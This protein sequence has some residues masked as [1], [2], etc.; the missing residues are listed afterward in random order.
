MD[1]ADT[2]RTTS[3]RYNFTRQYKSSRKLLFVLYYLHLFKWYIFNDDIRRVAPARMHIHY[4]H[5]LK[6][7]ESCFSR[8]PRASRPFIYSAM[9]QQQQE[10]QEQQQPPP[11]PG[12]RPHSNAATCV[13][14][15]TS[16]AASQ[17]HSRGV[18]RAAIAL[19]YVRQSFKPGAGAATQVRVHHGLLS[20]RSRPM[21]VRVDVLLVIRGARRPPFDAVGHEIIIRIFI[22]LFINN[23]KASLDCER[24]VE[25]VRSS[26]S[27][28]DLTIFRR[29]PRGCRGSCHLC[30]NIICSHYGQYERVYRQYVIQ[31]DAVHL[32]VDYHVRRVLDLQAAAAARVHDLEKF[33]VFSVLAACGKI[34]Q[35]DAVAQSHRQILDQ[36]ADDARQGQAAR[37]HDHRYDVSD[38]QASS[39]AARTCNS[40]LY[41]SSN[42]RLAQWIRE[43]HTYCTTCE[44][45]STMCARHGL[46]ARAAA[47]IFIHTYT[48][49]TCR[50][51]NMSEEMK[52]NLVEHVPHV[53]VACNDDFLFSYG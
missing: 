23:T 50:R 49:T 5:T 35:N 53:V 38:R 6:T 33:Q 10:Q 19:V 26:T 27:G 25:T 4:T 7:D 46:L 32:H 51:K 15:R 14:A 24:S 31:G 52:K 28:P 48:Y 43:A 47:C 20:C 34:V 44:S 22:A 2:P 18:D 13:T 42:S 3:Y 37:A 36:I 21:T 41:S 29:T 12:Q 8:L 30:K 11:A 40:C 45:L 39:S 16:R 1:D 17:A 9:Q